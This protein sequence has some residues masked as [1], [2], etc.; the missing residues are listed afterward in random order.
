MQRA[1]HWNEVGEA[2][3]LCLLMIFPLILGFIHAYVKKASKL[4]M[5]WFYYL[6]IGV[7]IQGVVTGI[8]QIVY[9]NF[10]GHYLQWP[11]SPYLLELGLANLSY[12]ILGVLSPWMRMGWQMAAAMGYGLFL[13]LTGIAYLIEIAKQGANSGNAGSF[14]YTDLLIPLVLFVIL[15]LINFKRV[16]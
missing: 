5:V 14:L 7:G 10:V 2:F 11:S 12:G 15:G 3:Y 1:I 9:P 6:G 13:L 4:E 8:V 16:N